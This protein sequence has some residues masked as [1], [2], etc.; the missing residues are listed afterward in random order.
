[1][2]RTLEHRPENHFIVPNPLAPQI[3]A[4]CRLREGY[5]ELAQ[6]KTDDNMYF[7]GV[8]VSGREGKPKFFRSCYAAMQYIASLS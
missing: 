1:M 6:G 7:Y 8:R 3:V 4:Y 5:A 2:L